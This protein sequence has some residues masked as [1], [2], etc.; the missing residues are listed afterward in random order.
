MQ[1]VKKRND[2]KYTFTRCAKKR[3]ILKAFLYAIFKEM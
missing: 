2:M 1:Y 3:K